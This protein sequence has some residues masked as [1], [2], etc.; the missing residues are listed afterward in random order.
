MARPTKTGLDYFPLDTHM[1][2]KIKLI[3]AKYGIE[4]FGLLIKLYQK[5]YNNGYYIDWQEENILLFSSEVNVSINQINDIINDCLHWKIFNEELYKNY[6]ILTSHGIQTRFIEA[7]KRRKKVEIIKEYNLLK[8]Y[9]INTNIVFVNINPVNVDI[10]PKNDNNNKQ[11]KVKESKVNNNTSSS[12]DNLIN[13][14]ESNSKK[15]DEEDGEKSKI[16]QAYFNAFNCMMSPTQLQILE[17]YIE[18]GLSEEI[19]ILALEQAALNNAK[20]LNY[21]QAILNNWV[22]KKISTVEQANQAIVEHKA[23]Q[24]NKSSPGKNGNVVSFERKG[25]TPEEQEEYYKSKGYR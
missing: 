1:E 18:D 16:P 24:K 5:I 14:H 25:M 2:D 8:D 20:S 6:S 19:I 11:S 13:C 15:S 4:G 21:V 7:T 9:E 3:E 17:S 10:N 23:K 22:K 12:K